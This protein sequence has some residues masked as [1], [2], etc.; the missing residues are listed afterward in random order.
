M[1]SSREI[2]A[3]RLFVGCWVWR[4][5]RRLT[6][7]FASRR[8]NLT[9]ALRP[10]LAVIAQVELRPCGVFVWG[11]QG[12]LMRYV[13]WAGY[14]CR[15]LAPPLQPPLLTRHTSSQERR[16]SI[17]RCR[18]SLPNSWTTLQRRETGGPM[19]GRVSCWVTTAPLV[20]VLA[21]LVLAWRATRWPLHTPP[22]CLHCPMQPH[23]RPSCNSLHGVAVRQVHQ[24]LVLA[25]SHVP[26]PPNLQC[27]MRGRAGQGSVSSDGGL[28]GEPAA[29]A[30]P[31]SQQ[32]LHAACGALPPKP[33][34]TLPPAMLPSSAQLTAS[35]PPRMCFQLVSGSSSEGAWG[36]ISRKDL[37]VVRSRAML[38][39]LMRLSYCSSSTWLAGKALSHCATLGPYRDRVSSSVGAGEAGRAGRGG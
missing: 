4:G 23:N 25:A 8:H 39:L 11:R 36:S 5:W 24:V 35:G 17:L 2:R 7:T 19:G 21:L 6:R 28:A 9:V 27:G 18:S 15:R 16:K 10:L 33:S 20:L 1:G 14:S 26:V 22:A 30:G 29:A 37:R 32:R 3:N 38:A 13:G 34:P 12:Q 31:S